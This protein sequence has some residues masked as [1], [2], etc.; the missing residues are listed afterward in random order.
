MGEVENLSMRDLRTMA[1]ST[2]GAFGRRLW[3]MSVSQAQRDLDA[4]PPP[5][6]V[7]QT[8]HLRK[9]MRRAAYLK[10]E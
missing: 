10:G 2:A 4:C 3:M 1:N 7:V 5:G 8:V 6:L 9:R